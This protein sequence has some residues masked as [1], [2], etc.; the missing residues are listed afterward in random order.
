M[1][2]FMHI[3]YPEKAWAD[4][5]KESLNIVFRFLDILALFAGVKGQSVPL[6][7]TSPG[8]H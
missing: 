3:I 7:A 4:R 2:S 5:L 8:L 1:A 6:T